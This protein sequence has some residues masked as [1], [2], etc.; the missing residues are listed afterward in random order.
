M[1]HVHKLLKG[2]L[3]PKEGKGHFG[4]RAFGTGEKTA[5]TNGP[6]K[7]ACVFGRFCS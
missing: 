2:D 3:K 5:Y 4:K 7:V 1:E 6:P